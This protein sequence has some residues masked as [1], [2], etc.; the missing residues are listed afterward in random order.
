MQKAKALFGAP[1][2]SDGGFSLIELMIAVALLP[3]PTLP[4]F[5]LT[6]PIR[7]QILPTRDM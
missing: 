6:P 3:P 7:H 1:Q 4:V 2:R 5:L